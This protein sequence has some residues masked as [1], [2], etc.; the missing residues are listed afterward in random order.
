MDLGLP[1]WNSRTRKHWNCSPPHW[2]SR[3]A[4]TSR[5]PQKTWSPPCWCCPG[6]CCR[7]PRCWSPRCCCLRNMRPKKFHLPRGCCCPGVMCPRRLK[8]W[9]GQAGRSVG[10]AGNSPSLPDSPHRTHSRSGPGNPTRDPGPASQ[11]NR[12]SKAA[13]AGTWTSI[14]ARLVR[15]ATCVWCPAE[16]Q[17]PRHGV[18]PPGVAYYSAPTKIPC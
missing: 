4:R 6:T 9:L 11:R 7:C 13:G 14:W 10:S 8:S 3:T 12:Q 15:C 16:R 18:G 5:R 17:A 1:R 2:N